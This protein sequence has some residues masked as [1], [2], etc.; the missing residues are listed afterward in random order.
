MNNI[1]VAKRYAKALFDTTTDVKTQSRY[2]YELQAFQEI[3]SK[4]ESINEFVHSVLI[5]PEKK[6]AVIIKAVQ[7]KG[8][9]GEVESFLGLLAKRGRLSIFDKVLEAFQYFVDDANG[10]TR[11]Y[12][13]S[14]SALSPEQRSQI[15]EKISEATNKKVILT[16]SEDPKV[17][18]GL[19]AEAGG[20]RFDDTLNTHLTRLKEELNRRTH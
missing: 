2:Y 11:G 16:Y 14:S 1:E 17:I 18:G 8:F 12:V 5:T 19:I 13:R 9:S 15:Q 7:N 20:F 6:E 3:L 10:V 4:E